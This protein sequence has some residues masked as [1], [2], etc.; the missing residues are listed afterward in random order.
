MPIPAARVTC[1]NP[2]R[3][4]RR[5]RGSVGSRQY[6]SSRTRN[7]LRISATAAAR[8]ACPRSRRRSVSERRQKSLCHFRFGHIP[9]QPALVPV[10]N[11]PQVPGA[12]VAH[13]RAC[14]TL[15]RCDFLRVLRSRVRNR[16][17][18]SSL[19]L[20]IRCRGDAERA[21]GSCRTRR[22]S[23][24]CRPWPCLRSR[25]AGFVWHCC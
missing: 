18:R 9:H 14:N 10:F 5:P 15:A 20:V 12:L 4:R 13:M 3:F 17:A 23:A 7:L 25:R 22:R 24:P 6:P 11:V 8:M 19:L 2:S 16:A 21:E 1:R